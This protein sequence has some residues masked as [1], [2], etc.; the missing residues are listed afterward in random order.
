MKGILIEK[1]IKREPI[2]VLVLLDTAFYVYST[3]S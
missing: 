3:F 2:M 1:K